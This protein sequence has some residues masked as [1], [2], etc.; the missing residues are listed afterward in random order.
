MMTSLEERLHHI[1]LNTKKN[2]VSNKKDWYKIGKALLMDIKVCLH[3]ESKVGV[4]RIYRLYSVM[5]GNWEGPS[6]RQLSKM[7]RS[8]FNEILKV[9]QQDYLAAELLNQ[10]D[11]EE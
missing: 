7:K 5:K 4:R 11:S 10:F 1:H 9:Y 8:Q 3:N 6:P 2:S